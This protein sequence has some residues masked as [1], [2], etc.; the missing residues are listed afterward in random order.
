[1]P[2]H[3]DISARFPSAANWAN[4][5]GLNL[6][7]QTAGEHG[8]V[9]KTVELHRNQIMLEM[10]GCERF[11]DFARIAKAKLAPVTF[12]TSRARSSF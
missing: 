9:E 10:G 2:E 3:Y 5:V 7:K 6:N 4:L 11:A 8:F 1:L 12:L